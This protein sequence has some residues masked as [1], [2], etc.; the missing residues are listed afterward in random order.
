[1]EQYGQIDM[2]VDHI[3]HMTGSHLFFKIRP[4]PDPGRP[5]RRSRSGTSTAVN[6]HISSEM[7]ISAKSRYSG[8]FISTIGGRVHVYIQREEM[9]GGDSEIKRG[10]S[11]DTHWLLLLS[12]DTSGILHNWAD[13]TWS[14]ES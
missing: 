6:S 12:L 13:I 5:Y 11:R 3:I 9:R 1:M 14:H 2:D 10:N 7:I 4:K 8:Q